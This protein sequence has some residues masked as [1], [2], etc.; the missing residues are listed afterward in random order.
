MEKSVIE[1][2]LESDDCE[3]NSIFVSILKTEDLDMREKISAII[4]L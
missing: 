1:N 3:I 4:G 2:N